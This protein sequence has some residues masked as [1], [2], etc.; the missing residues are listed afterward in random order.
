MYKCCF[1][2]CFCASQ[3]QQRQKTELILA[4]TDS[5]VANHWPDRDQIW[6][7][8]S[9]SPGNGH[10]LKKLTSRASRGIWRGLGGH[11]CIQKCGNRPWHWTVATTG[12]GG[13]WIRKSTGPPK[14]PLAP[15]KHVMNQIIFPAGI[16]DFTRE[17]AYFC[18]LGYNGPFLLKLPYYHQKMYLVFDIFCFY[19]FYIFLHDNGQVYLS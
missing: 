19:K 4:V 1:L 3:H 17:V 9:D 11:T 7:T 15:Q 14:N 2:A 6:H 18:T 13:Q 10:R 8:Y 12:P 16:Y 5:P